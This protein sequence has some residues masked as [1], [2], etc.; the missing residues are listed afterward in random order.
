[1]SKI[2]VTGGLG[3][4]GHNVVKRLLDQEHEVCVTDICTNYGMIPQEEL[5]YLIAERRKKIPNARIHRV[6][7]VDQDGVDWLFKTYK[8]DTVIHLASF[9]RQ[10]VVNVNP[11]TGSR[12]MSEG[13]LNLLEA[14]KKHNTY[15]FVYISSSM[16]Y[17]NFTDDVHEDAVCHP[18]GQYGIMKLAGEWLV[19]DYTRSTGMA[20]VIIRPSAV[21]GPLDVEDRVVSKFLLTAMRDGCIQ[22]NGAGEKLDFTYVDDVADG[23]V[24]A[25][26]SA[27]T[28]NNTYN[29][30]KSHSES[31]I[32]AAE[33]AI[34]IVGKGTIE[35]R[36]RDLDFPSRG[37]LN[38]DAAKQ[39]FNFNP[40]VNI[41]QGFQ[42][43]YEWLNNSI[44]WSQK[45]VS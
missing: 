45:T 33:L 25:A 18:Q 6:D 40:K 10:K 12:A 11:Q 22:V 32:E 8:P 28:N 29:I 31:L 21:Y 27:N 24:A 15:K 16:I 14:S 9:P 35:V 2:L 1:M 26:L 5:D 30:T 43:Y 19:R 17:G 39:D 23:I 38:I 41:N 37:A 4:I 7:I 34:K 3:L 44:Y 20:H 36:D 42:I 13:L